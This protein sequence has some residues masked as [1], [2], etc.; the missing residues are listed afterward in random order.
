MKSVNVEDLRI[1]S[2][3]LFHS[4]G[5]ASANARFPSFLSDRVI[6]KSACDEDRNPRL[7]GRD[8]QGVTSEDT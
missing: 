4:A 6:T 1:K 3:S 7:E 8:E 5:S 2:G